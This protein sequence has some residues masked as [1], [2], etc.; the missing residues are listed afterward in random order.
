MKPEELLHLFAPYLPTDRF[1]AVLSNS[2]LPSSGDGAAL[3]ADISGF[4]P[5]TTRLVEEFGAQRAV[6]EL[7]RR[8]NPMFEAIA[9]QVFIHGGSVIRFTGDG[10]IAW[11]NNSGPDHTGRTDS[12]AGVPAISRAIAAG[13]GMQAVMPLFKGLRLKVCVGAGVAFRW[14]VGQPEFGLADVLSG[15][16]VEAMSSLGGEAQP[17]QVM[18]HSEIIPLLDREDVTMEIA[19]TGNANVTSISDTINK[20][21]RLHRWPAWSITGDIE[22]ILNV[23]RP[24]VAAPIRAQ[25]EKGFGDFVAELR[26][27]MPM[28]VQFATTVR[29][30][31]DPRQILDNYV[32]AVQNVVA[33]AGGRLVS[34][35]VGDKGNVLLVVFGVPTTYGDDAERALRTALNLRDIAAGLDYIAWQRIGLS[36]GLLYAGTLGGE[37]R[38]DYTTIGEETNIASRLMSVASPGQILVSSSV[39]K[40]VGPHVVFEDLPP[41]MVKGRSEPVAITTPIA[42]QTGVH[43][44][45]HVSKF[46]GR[47]TE[48]AQLRKQLKAV[49]LGLP[50]IVRVEGQSGIG[51]SRLIAELTQIATEQNFQAAG[52]DCVSTGQHTAYLPW[53]DALVSLLNLDLD[54]G[55][56]ENVARLHQFVNGIDDSW[57]PRLPLL[58]D[59]LG[60]PIEDSPLTAK[61]EG[62][63]RREALFALANDLILHRSRQQPLLLIL[64]DTQWIDEVSE[65]LTIELARRLSIEPAP[66]MLV[67]IHRPAQEADHP[68]DLIKTVNEMHLHTHMIIKE[69]S[70]A[71]A[72]AMIEKYL[73]VSSL[74]AELA[75]FV[76]DRSQG[77]PF[78]IQEVIDTLRETGFVKVVGSRVHVERALHEADIPQTVQGLVQARIDRLNEIDKMVLKVAAVIGREFQV[79]VLAGSIPVEM[80]Y[81]ELL[82]RLQSLEEHDFSHMYEGEPDLKYLFKHAITQE[83]TYQSLPF[84]Q[85]RQLHRAVAQRL[86]GIMPDT[87]ERLAY[88]YARSGEDNRARHYLILAGQKAFKEYANQAALGYFTQV[89]EL[90]RTEREQFDIGCQRLE[91]LLRLGDTK[92]VREDLPQLVQLAARRSRPDWNATIHLFWA[93]YYAQTSVWPRVI[94]ETQKAIAES[95]KATNTLLIWQAYLLQR[96]AFLAISQR[97][98]AEH[99]TELMQP[100]AQNLN[101]ERNNIKLRLM[102]IDDMYLTAPDKATSDALLLIDKIKEMSDPVLEAEF[103]SIL[104]KF[105]WL[106]NALIEALDAYRQEISLLRQVGDR[107]REGITLNQIGITLVNLGQLSEGNAHLLDAYKILHQIGERSG[108]AISLVNLG[109]IAHNHKAYDEALAYMR[110]GLAL[111]RQLNAEADA[112]RTLFYM[113]NVFI[114]NDDL[115]SAQRSFDEARDFLQANNL[116][117]YVDELYTALSDIDLRR[118]D[119]VAARAHINPLLARL[120]AGNLSYLIIP[121]LAYWRTIYALREC[122]EPEKAEALRQTYLQRIAGI[123]ARLTERSWD[124]AFVEALWYHAALFAEPEG[125]SPT[126]DTN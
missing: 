126:S 110:R 53:R 14:V 98:E 119:H 97:E 24:Y 103:W 69:F 105:Y 33:T 77:N 45:A 113:G 83:V 36:R 42:I 114:A 78:F 57:L 12:G 15:P 34:V 86:E 90:A 124:K 72:N 68:P 117:Q 94:D 59:L 108:E 29:P 115:P 116:P 17:G 71:D 46:V 30:G 80:S 123:L 6:E 50:R 65:A 75:R 26:Y 63:T 1:R 51:K 81:E 19:S 8:V 37:V 89:Q 27:A 44:Q 18:I 23:L 16:A 88:H 49:K 47:E 99:L 41:V 106:D 62:R 61:L 64:E 100:F 67:L 11:F 54:A 111:Q 104:A 2:D 21:A 85:R 91:V 122:G 120:E 35:E 60:L 82:A 56:D 5:L 112:A 22:A 28:F 70:R 84:A 96:E 39:R 125:E 10:F 38:H 52:G 74:P 101:D 79:R 87:I 25:I 95:Q 7:N 102:Q 43:R 40:E 66:A 31:D 3:M 48:L 93:H 118:D 32:S 9:G 4:T 58:G 92:G 121:G 107:R 20:A 55:I 73:N 13:L 109:V 76:Y